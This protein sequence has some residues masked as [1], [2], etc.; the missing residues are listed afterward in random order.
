MTL[1]DKIYEGK[2]FLKELNVIDVKDFLKKLEAR[3]LKKFGMNAGMVVIE[4]IREEAG[5]ELI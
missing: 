1:S 2:T 3:M 5:K 4:I